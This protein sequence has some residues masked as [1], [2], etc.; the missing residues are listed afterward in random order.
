[1]NL[2]PCCKGWPKYS[3]IVTQYHE[4]F[5]NLSPFV[6]TDSSY[7]FSPQL[8]SVLPRSNCFALVYRDAETLK[9]TKHINAGV[10]D[11]EEE[12]RH[13]FDINCKYYE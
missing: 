7:L 13:Y 2:I 4:V 10:L 5:N 6:S 1:M 9:F 3:K 8:L 12:D 11:L